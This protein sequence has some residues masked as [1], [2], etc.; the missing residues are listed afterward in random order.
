M[1]TERLVLVCVP[2]IDAVDVLNIAIIQFVYETVEPSDGAVG[3][4]L[5]PPLDL[6]VS[7]MSSRQAFTR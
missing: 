5:I 1:L 2:A 7:A 4:R 3:L 6:D